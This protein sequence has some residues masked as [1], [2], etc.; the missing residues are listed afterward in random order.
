M[1][2]SAY[3]YS[4]EVRSELIRLYSEGNTVSDCGLIMGLSLSTLNYWIRKHKLMP[5]MLEFKAIN[6]KGIL[7]R[8]LLKTANGGLSSEITKE[9]TEVIKVDGEDDKVI[10]VT[11]KIKVD[12]PCSKAIQILSKKY[13]KELAVDS[14]I[15]DTTSQVNINI[16]TSDM[17]LRELQQVSAVSPLGD[18]I[19][20][21]SVP[22][23][24][25]DTNGRAIDVV[26]EE[27]SVE[28][29]DEVSHSELLPP[30]G[31]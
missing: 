9:Y 15:V 24:L 28:A 11:E 6:I 17:S 25:S 16:N 13:H 1:A 12:K 8:G 23:T 22:V 2:K 14:D 30:S 29:L 20:A 31:D 19:D 4:L 21:S 7:E 5:V 27:R 26:S 3:K 10:K 18:I